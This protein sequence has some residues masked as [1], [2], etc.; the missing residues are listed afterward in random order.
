LN[1]FFF[2]NSGEGGCE[3]SK[4]I[5]WINWDS[6]CLP[7]NYG[8]LGVRRMREFNLSLL[9][10]WCWRLLGKKEE[11]WYRVLKARYGEVGGCIKEGGND[12]SLW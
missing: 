11:L 6:I 8:G 5:A 2:K 4:K 1:L 3:V 9:E 7:V 10:K 12:A